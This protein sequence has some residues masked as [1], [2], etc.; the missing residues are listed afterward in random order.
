VDFLNIVAL[1][2][3]QSVTELLPVG[4]EAHVA[5]ASRVLPLADIAEQLMIPVYLGSVL[6]V[7]A[8]FHAEL[9]AALVGAYHLAVGRTSDNARLTVKLV[10]GSVPVIAVG[11]ALILLD[12][13]PDGETTLL[14]LGWTMVGF[15]ALLFLADRIGMTL[16]RIEHMSGGTA[17]AI[18]LA[19][20]VALVP[21]AG[22]IGI[23]MTAAR[24]LGFERTDA[25]RFAMLL[26][27]VPILAFAAWHTWTLAS[28]QGWAMGTDGAIA[29]G[30][31]F[32]AA[33]GAITFLMQWLKRGSLAP[34]AL[35]RLIVG[36]ALLY[37]VYA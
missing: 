5:L 37:A 20:A 21:G 6:A 3:V 25:A 24:L 28:T 33:L 19:Q 14:L 9:W 31:A 17:L 11:V 34:F 1:A 2:V 8:Y 23:T 22:R 7:L 27:V 36:A 30:V 26:G 10:I 29:A 15:G 35:Y 32:V 12:A 13:V 4:S 18:G 16:R